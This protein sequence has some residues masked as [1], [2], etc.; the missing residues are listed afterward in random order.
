MRIQIIENINNS[1]ISSYLTWFKEFCDKLSHEHG[2]EP[3]EWF[4]HETIDL[5][6]DL[7]LKSVNHSEVI[8]GYVDHS[9]ES[10]VQGIHW[11]VV[12]VVG[13]SDLDPIVQVLMATV[14][15]NYMQSVTGGFSTDLDDIKQVFSHGD[16]GYCFATSWKDINNSIEKVQDNDT[17]SL[18]FEIKASAMLLNKHKSVIQTFQEVETLMN[19]N[20]VFSMKCLNIINIAS[21]INL[22]VS[23]VFLFVGDMV[24]VGD[25]LKPKEQKKRPVKIMSAMKRY[26]KD[27]GLH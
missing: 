7:F 16:K 21:T 17:E 5:K 26:I 4:H 14:G 11:V 20:P 2:I 3:I 9:F 22:P 8:I 24:F 18:S 6:S 13:T 27:D 19:T 23:N 10:T 1:Q 12:E 15:I 25:L